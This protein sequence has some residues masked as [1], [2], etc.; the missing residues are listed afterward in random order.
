MSLLSFIKQ[1]A[2]QDGKPSSSRI[3]GYVMG[4][5]IVLATL[6]YVGI[7][8]ANAVIAFRDKGFYT[9]PAT[10]V[11]IFGMIL[12]H[13]LTLFGIYKYNE[14]QSAIATSGSTTVADTTTVQTTVN[15][16]PQS[17]TQPVAE[18]PETPK[19]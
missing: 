19:S 5:Q 8:I 14:T 17:T 11:T 1:S 15:S 6:C 13:Q 18:N 12:T 16:T 10:H 9:I 7:E 3:M 4:A 2:M